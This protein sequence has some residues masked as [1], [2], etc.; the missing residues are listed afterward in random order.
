MFLILLADLHARI[1][2]SLSRAV[3]SCVRCQGT[4]KG[5]SRTSMQLIS[6]V[7]SPAAMLFSH[8]P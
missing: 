2:C 6:H 5:R 4:G 8:L 1:M 3:S 7:A